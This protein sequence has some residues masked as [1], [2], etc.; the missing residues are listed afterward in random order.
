MSTRNDCLLAAGEDGEFSMLNLRTCEPPVQGSLTGGRHVEVNSIEMSTSR[1]GASHAYI[2][3]NDH[4]VRNIDLETL[5]L[6][7][8]FPA[9]WFANYATQSPDKH[10]VC[11][12]G[13]HVD[14][15]IF[16][17]NSREAIA[18]L[19]GHTQFSFACAWTPD[20]RLVAT[21]SD[22][23]SV[24]VYDTRQMTWPLMTLTNDIHSSVRSMR[25]S[26]DGRFLYFAEDGDSV[27]II[28]ASTGYRKGQSIDFIGNIAGFAVTS[29][30]SES[31]IIGASG[32]PYS[33]L[34]EFER[35]TADDDEDKDD[36]YWS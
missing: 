27:K 25:Y 18:T 23:M 21:G 8:T 9:E 13:D 36:P 35:S 14:G 11:V 24:M 22:D 10:M 5:S 1:S 20:G 6:L 12:V 15:K 7:N 30:D 29:P 34:L 33:S 3:T 32:Q 2:T 31:L 4:V 19:K 28:D 16:S 26:D 17:V